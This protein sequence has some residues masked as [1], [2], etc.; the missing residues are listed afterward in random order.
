VDHAQGKGF[1]LTDYAKNLIKFKARQLG[2]R[3]EFLPADQADLQ[4]ELWL[5]LCERA[6]AFDPTKA[7]LDTFID[8]VVNTAVGVILR[9]RRRQIAPGTGRFT[10][11]SKKRQTF[12]QVLR[13]ARLAK[14]ITLRKFAE[15]VG[16]SPTYLSQVEQDNADPPTI[17]KSKTIWADSWT[18][19]ASLAKVSRF[20]R[21]ICTPAIGGGRRPTVN[22]NR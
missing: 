18:T 17:A 20:G 16:I 1:V 3:R 15:M 9:N 6:A 10:A 19:A 8:R 14:G 11:M 22:A 21:G 5:M 13:E 7:A 4:Q 2:R 12:G